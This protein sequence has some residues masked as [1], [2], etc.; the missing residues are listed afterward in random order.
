MIDCRFDYEYSGGHIEGAINLPTSSQ[1]EDFF[2]SHGPDHPLYGSADELP[3]PTKSGC[4]DPA[5]NAKKTI[6]VFHCEFSCKRAP[7]L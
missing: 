1:V 5:G 2:L 4:P 7:T 3:A 6:L